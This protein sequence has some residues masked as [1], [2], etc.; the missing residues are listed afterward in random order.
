MWGAL[1]RLQSLRVALD[2]WQ[3]PLFHLRMGH[4][5]GGDEQ[6]QKAH[7]YEAKEKGRIE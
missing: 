5:R 4:R 3:F 6:R 7:E 2:I 1:R